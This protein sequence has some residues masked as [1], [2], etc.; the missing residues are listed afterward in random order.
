VQQDLNPYAA[1]AQR[2]LQQARRLTDAGRDAGAFSATVNAVALMRA[3]AQAGT[4]LPILLTQGLQPFVSA[5]RAGAPIARQ[6]TDAAGALA[7]TSP[8]R[9]TDAS[10]L[11]AAYGNLTDA[12]SLAQFAQHLF[13]AKTPT[14]EAD[15]SQVA[16]GAVYY[17]FAGALVDAAH[18]IVAVAR[19]LG[20]ASLA[21]NVDVA[22]AADAFHRAARANLASFQSLVVAPRAVAGRVGMGAASDAI[23]QT[24]TVFALARTGDRVLDALPQALGTSRSPEYGALAGSVALYVRTATL[25]AKYSSL[26][27][28]DR[29]TLQLTALANRGAFASVMTRARARLAASLALLRAN[30][31]NPTVVAAD[32]EIGTA[33]QGGAVTDKFDALGDFWDGYVNS[34]VLAILGGFPA[35]R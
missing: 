7:G 3:I 14:G 24:D 27:V 29:Q 6:I 31:V 21:P 9:V 20:G 25:L 33:D 18:D 13:V 2:Q 26:G 35:P 32:Y 30:H 8:E 23:A 11:L 1:A 12:A 5:V 16:E 22:A 19:D 17:G 15:L 10:A 28:V 34:R 4:S